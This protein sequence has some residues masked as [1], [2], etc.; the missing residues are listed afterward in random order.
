[1][2]IMGSI[3]ING[4]YTHANGDSGCFL[5]MTMDGKVPS[6][7]STY[8]QFPVIG[9]GIV[10]VFAVLFL[11]YWAAV[12]Q[13][14][15]EFAPTIVSKIFMGFS[16][17]LAVFAFSICG[18]LGIGLNIG[19]RS[20]TSGQGLSKCQS[21][22]DSFQALNTAQVSAGLMGGFLLVAFTLELI[23]YKNLPEYDTDPYNTQEAYA[24]QNP[25]T[26]EYQA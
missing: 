9:A 22:V 14:Y 21:T 6:F 2:I 10:S 13:R 16:V 24:H 5:Y 12:V 3:G 8:C 26:S 23:Q 7:N 11:G 20:V 18:E 25:S 17:L 1:M 19:C 15:D 4:N